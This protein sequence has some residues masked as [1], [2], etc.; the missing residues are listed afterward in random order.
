MWTRDM[1]NNFLFSI[2]S[3]VE[4]FCTFSENM[5]IKGQLQK[6]FPLLSESSFTQLKFF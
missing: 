1:T 4:H 3:R 5:S 6:K 2:L